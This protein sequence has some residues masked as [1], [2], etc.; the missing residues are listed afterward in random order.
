M[1]NQ[2]KMPTR[3]EFD[4]YRKVMREYVVYGTNSDNTM[5]AYI[6]VKKD[7][8][9]QKIIFQEFGIT[10]REYFKVLGNKEAWRNERV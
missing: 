3:E 4:I 10:Y 7:K 5:E 9:F 2:N 1:K 6:K 8:D